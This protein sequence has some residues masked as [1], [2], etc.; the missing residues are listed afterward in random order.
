MVKNEDNSTDSETQ[1]DKND[2]KS[3]P[4]LVKS[5]DST[6]LKKILKSDGLAKSCKDC[7]N[8]DLSKTEDNFDDGSV[9]D[10][11]LWLCMRCGVQLCGRFK[12]K[13]ALSHFEV[14]DE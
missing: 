4:H 12:N 9:T 13:H 6:K 5:L 7:N 10:E 11:S 8:L 14:S 2:E 3:C 1:L